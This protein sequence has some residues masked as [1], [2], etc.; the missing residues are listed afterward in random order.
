MGNLTLDVDIAIQDL[1]QESSYK[2]LGINEGN[3]IQH[4]KMKEK[5]RKE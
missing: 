1:E 2:Y 3:A 5:I 4:A